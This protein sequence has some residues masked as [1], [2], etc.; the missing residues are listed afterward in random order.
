MRLSHLEP[1]DRTQLDAL[2]RQADA[3]VQDRCDGATLC[4]TQLDV[5]TLQQLLARCTPHELSPEQERAVA[6]ALGRVVQHD[7]LDGDWVIV[8]GAHQRGFA[9]RRPG[10]LNW[11]SPE[12]ALRS[13]L[14]GRAQPDLPR[15]YHALV[16][17]LNPRNPSSPAT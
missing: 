6:A 10:T 1:S 2:L 14:H 5:P 3:L 13:H 16:A 7:Q 15:L 11:V 17:R 4:G 9:I 12:G 8:E